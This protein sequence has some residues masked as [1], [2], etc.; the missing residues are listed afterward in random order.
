MKHRSLNS[1]SLQ[2]FEDCFSTEIGAWLYLGRKRE[3]TK[4]M[5]RESHRESVNL[6]WI[7]RQSRDGLSK[8]L[9]HADTKKKLFHRKKQKQKEKERHTRSHVSENSEKFW[10][11]FYLSAS[12]HFT[13]Y[14]LGK[15]KFRFLFC[16]HLNFSFCGFDILII[17]LMKWVL[18]KSDIQQKMLQPKIVVVEKT[19]NLKRLIL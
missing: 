12:L 18:K 10:S 9:F 14:Q 7:K 4:T 3:K 15:I 6:S 5:E 8:K 17:D 16:L 2:T 11:K 19:L 1:F 13:F